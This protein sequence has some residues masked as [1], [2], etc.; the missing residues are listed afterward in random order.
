MFATYL[1]ARKLN[2]FSVVDVAWAAG[3]LPI[4]LFYAVVGEGAF[5]HKMTFV[6][7][8]GVW[9]FRLGGFLYSRVKRHHP[10]ED[11]RYQELR[12]EWSSNLNRKFFWFY[13]FQAVLLWLLSAPGAIVSVNK[14]VDL[15]LAEWLGAVIW[16]CGLIGESVAD[17]QAERFK[18]DPS[19]TG[20]V[21]QIGLWRYSRHPN[22]FFESIIWIGYFV[23]AL[24]SP[25]GWVTI[26]CPALILWLLLKVT[27]IP[28][29][30]QRSLKSRGEAYREY[31]RTT[32]AF[33]PLPRKN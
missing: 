6:I 31:Q 13:Q 9:S 12:R 22:Y 4:V 30:E 21:C 18:E 1:V 16:I 25:K 32:S 15:V 27:G 7:M 14:S 17:T 8:M 11:T 26:Y 23:F 3:F 24:G 29:S 28:Y 5:T 10:V 33:I 19:N 20:K 2:N